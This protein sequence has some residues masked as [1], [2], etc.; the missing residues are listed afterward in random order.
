M[1]N[2]SELTEQAVNRLTLKLGKLNTE[3]LSVSDYNKK[4]LRRYIHDLSFYMAVY[5]QLMMKALN[6]LHVPVEEAVF[7]DYGG[8]S[9]LLSFLAYETGFKSV[10]YTDIF[11]PSAEDAQ[12]IADKLDIKVDRFICGDIDRIVAELNRLQIKPHLICSIDVLEHIYDLNRW[13]RETYKIN[14]DFC[15]VFMTSANPLNPFIKHRLRRAHRVTEYKGHQR[16]EGWKEDA[17]HS[18]FLQARREIIHNSFPEIDN[19]TL[20][21]LAK[22][23]RGL[24]KDD[25]ERVVSDFLETGAMRYHIKDPTNTCD[26]F[27]GNWSEHLINLK[28]LR[29][30]I[31]DSGMTVKFT[32]SYYSYS[33]NALLNLPKF[34]LNMYLR[35]SSNKN[36]WLSPTYTVEACKSSHP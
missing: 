14:S 30:I 15:L 8:G 33:G 3:D 29:Q 17:L 36:L 16:H 11:S 2:I 31:V 32:N 26:P 19:D 34:L 28:E 6:N 20:D 1:K 25:I 27:N 13:F 4:Y 10:I 21:T 22:Q 24:R 7:V 23:T 9:G 35:F 12:V 18:S 5:K